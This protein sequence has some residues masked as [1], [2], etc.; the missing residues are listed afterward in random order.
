MGHKMIPKR[1][2]T[3]GLAV[4]RFEVSKIWS[5]CPLNLSVTLNVSQA[6]PSAP[7]RGQML[8]LERESHPRSGAPGLDSGVVK[9]HVADGRA[10][11]FESPTDTF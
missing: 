10:T 9:A 4:T 2:S 7:I 6:S 8:I 5:P 1:P 11:G 3:R